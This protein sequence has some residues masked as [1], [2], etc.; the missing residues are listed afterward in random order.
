MGACNSK[1]EISLK[2][3]PTNSK[4]SERVPI[5]TFGSLHFNVNVSTIN[6]KLSN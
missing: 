5:T 1:S 3:L 4:T 2:S 6:V